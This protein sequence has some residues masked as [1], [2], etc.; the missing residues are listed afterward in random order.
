MP[1]HPEDSVAGDSNDLERP[2]FQVGDKCLDQQVVL[3]S[4]ETARPATR[5]VDRRRFGIAK[6]LPNA[7]RLAVYVSSCGEFTGVFVPLTKCVRS[8]LMEGCC[9][10]FMAVG[11]EQVRGFIVDG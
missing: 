2:S 1:P 6:L 10:H 9:V 5:R 11:A 8:V 7:E 3:A 4:E